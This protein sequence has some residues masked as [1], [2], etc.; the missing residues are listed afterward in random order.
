M[1]NLKRPIQIILMAPV[2]FI[3][4]RLMAQQ[5]KM[6]PEKV[7]YLT[8][9]YMPRDWYRQQAELWR[10]EVS[11]NPTNG[12]AWQNYYP[13]TEYSYLES[14][15][16]AERDA[17][18]AKIIADMQIAIAGEAL[19]DLYKYLVAQKQDEKLA[20]VFFTETGPTALAKSMPGL[21]E[22]LIL[23]W[24]NTRANI[25]WLESA[26]QLRPDDPETYDDMI[27]H[28]ETTGDA[29]KAKEFCERLYKSRDI[30]TGLLEY[31]YNILMSTEKNA[32]L[33]TNG[34]N[35][36]FP[37]W[38]LQRAKGIRPDVT[39]LNVHLIKLPDYL[40]MLLQAK[41]VEIDF[42]KISAHGGNHRIPELCKA[43]A[44]ASPTLPTYFALTVDNSHT[45]ALASNLYVTGL[46]SRYSLRRLDNVALLQDNIE[47]RFRLDYLKYDW[48][49]ETHIT[50]GLIKEL[51]VNYV[52]PFVMLS[53]HYTKN[54][55]NK[56]AGYWKNFAID[57]AKAGG[58][59]ALIDHIQS[60]K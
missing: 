50:A 48:Y 37:I 51:N 1:K 23:K 3:S 5:E 29:A 11:Q 27:V 32:I 24:R 46:A 26:Y 35:D 21:Y 6:Q 39:V 31:N 16:T 19:P 56:K 36:T 47:N 12:A 25:R 7:Y 57:L 58:D 15:A 40:K 59:H 44:S 30:V 13:A 34:D 2:V 54:G 53:E 17:K 45:K 28:Y 60:R 43:I 18:L 49:H 52:A 4:A 41:N 38:V 10:N 14:M 22:F 33:F 9:Q 42:K 20:K 55:E 8:K